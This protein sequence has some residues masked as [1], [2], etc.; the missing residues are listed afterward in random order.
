MKPFIIAIDGPSG[1]GKSTLARGLAQHFGF[2]LVETGAL[3]RLVALASLRAK[4]DGS[5]AALATLLGTLSVDLHWDGEKS[6]A[7]LGDKEVQEELRDSAVAERASA[8]AAKPSVRSWLLG[9]Q[10]SLALA[11][12]KGSVL[13][14]RD[15]GTVVFPDADVKLYLDAAPQER[16]R[17]RHFEFSSAQRA[18]PSLEE[19][20]AALARRDTRDASRV[21]APLKAAADAHF[22]DTSSLNAEEV[23]ANASA[24]VRERLHG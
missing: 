22:I 24:L 9:R 1:V 8:L 19:I 15:I 20:E 10:R 7:L 11:A 16:A 23:L 12:A 18:V 17:R 4:F 14:G 13:E 5:D 2:T 21:A 6:I 3:Y